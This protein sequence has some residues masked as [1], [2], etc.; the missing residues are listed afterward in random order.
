MRARLALLLLALGLGGAS[1]PSLAPFLPRAANAP[2]FLE[3]LTP[4]DFIDRAVIEAFEK[5]SGRTVALDTYASPAELAERSAERRYDLVALSGPALARRL[6]TL[7]RLDRAAL[8]NAR[9]VQ[10]LVAAKYAAY[11]RD[12]AHGVPFGWSAF[13]LLYDS[14]K[15]KE[16]PVSFV[17]ALG[18]SREARRFADCGIVWPDARV[19]SFLAVWRLTGLDPARARPQDVKSAAAVLDRARGAML[20]FAAPDEVGALAK[21]AG[22]LGAGTAGEAAAV[23]E[24]GGD[25]APSI[26][27]AYPREGAP[28]TIYAYAIPAN[29]ASPLAAYQLLDA[30]LAPDNLRRDAALAGLN[31]AEDDSDLDTLRRLPPEPLLDPAVDAA[32]QAEWKRLTS[33]K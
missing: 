5:Q 2:K 20:A 7:V 22:C 21:G 27:F 3:V 6:P 29:A 13:G 12:G 26:R 23:A 11:D 31:S 30:L 17:Q 1:A 18:L 14:D 9:R 25:G 10:P 8:A 19:Q 28:L 4:P 24:R 15:L 16:A 32:M 33:A